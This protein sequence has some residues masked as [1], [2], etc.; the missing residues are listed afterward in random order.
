[1]NLLKRC[2]TKSMPRVSNQLKRVSAIMPVD[3]ILLI[4][5][6]ISIALECVKIPIEIVEVVLPIIS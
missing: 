6:K 2:P 1:M 5:S 4:S 3:R